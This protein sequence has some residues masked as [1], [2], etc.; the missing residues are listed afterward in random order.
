MATIF[1]QFNVLLFE[2]MMHVFSLIEKGLLCIT[3]LS[4]LYQLYRGGQF[5]WGGGSIYHGRGVKIPWVGVNI[6]WVG[7]SIYM[8]RKLDIL[9]IGVSK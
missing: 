3:P 2:K 8:G 9:W 6:P 7:G 5:Y 4:T 1:L